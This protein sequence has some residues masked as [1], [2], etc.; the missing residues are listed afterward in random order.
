MTYTIIPDVPGR[1]TITFC[2]GH[3]WIPA[4]FSPDD[5]LLYEICHNCTVIREAKHDMPLRKL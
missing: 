2:P 5:V 3:Q 1:M 4:S